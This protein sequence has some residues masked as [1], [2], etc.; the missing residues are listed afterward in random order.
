MVIG[1]KDA[2]ARLPQLVK[3]VVEAG[4]EIHMGARQ[5]DE[6]TLIATE[7]LAE[8]RREL[9]LLR[10][11]NQG[12]RHKIRVLSESRPATEQQPFAGLQEMLERG[13]LGVATGGTRTRRYLPAATYTSELSQD[14]RSSLGASG[15][16][17]PAIRRRSA[18]V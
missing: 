3:H 13:H 8:L 5:H 10:E 14:Q 9:G 1:I 4:E 6:A 18:R 7:Q 12:L 17:E 15:A 11:E 16:A 2:R